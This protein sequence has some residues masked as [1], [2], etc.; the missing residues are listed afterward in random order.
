[1]I[2]MFLDDHLHTDPKDYKTLHNFDLLSVFLF[3][4]ECNF[5]KFWGN[6][7]HDNT[8]EMALVDFLFETC[9]PLN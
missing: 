7:Y 9:V 1:M 3:N 2:A 5:M 4:I 8:F 6:V